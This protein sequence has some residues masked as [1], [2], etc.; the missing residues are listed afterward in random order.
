MTAAF[1]EEVS[2]R[3]Q[4]VPPDHLFHYTGPEGL[5]AICRTK[6]LYAGRAQDM[7]DQSEQKL[8][9]ELTEL[10][11]RNRLN[12]VG[13]PNYITDDR[14]SRFVRHL[15]DGLYETNRQL[16]TVSLSSE[17]DVL[18]QWRVD[19][20][21]SGGGALGLPARHL[22]RVADEQG[23][24]LAKCIYDW[25]QQYTFV[26]IMLNRTIER[27]VNALTKD[28]EGV[29][30]PV[31]SRE[32]A[33]LLAEYGPLIKHGSFAE[34][35][36]WRLVSKPRQIND[37]RLI[38]RGSPSGIRMFYPFELFTSTNPS[39]DLAQIATSPGIIVGP[40]IDSSAAQMAAQSLLNTSFGV[41]TWHGRTETPYR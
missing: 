2:R 19:C 9:V 28:N 17:R 7:N 11:I 37:S 15:A 8:A 14:I 6:Q 21:R 26:D 3:L 12:S 34:E 35:H 13:N 5:I 24:Y 29:V 4:E 27:F 20:P 30:I 41:G 22:R 10:T 32:H 25:S 38:Y 31:Y 36:E 18:S 39:F 40:N 1:D 33:A 16:Y 23:F